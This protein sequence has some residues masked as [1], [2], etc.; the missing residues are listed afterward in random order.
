MRIFLLGLCLAAN[1]F[2]L[3]QARYVETVNASGSFPLVRAKSAA[4]VYVDSGDYAGV[5]RAAGDRVADVARVTGSTP[6]MA[7]DE[8]SLG[9]N[10][11]I[12]GTIGKS[13]LIDRLI[14]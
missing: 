3:G 9:A 4:A 1:A 10:A 11:V 5:V 13:A 6:A 14:L 12:A 8:E 7:H 2:A